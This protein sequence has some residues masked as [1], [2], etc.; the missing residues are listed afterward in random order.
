MEQAIYFRA[1]ASFEIWKFFTLNEYFFDCI[2]TNV[3]NKNTQI[4]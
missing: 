1:Y 4:D 3:N 2:S